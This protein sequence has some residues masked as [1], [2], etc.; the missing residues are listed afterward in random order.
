MLDIIS[1]SP[2][3]TH[4]WKNTEKEDVSQ[5]LNLRAE[6]LFY[7]MVDLADESDSEAPNIHTENE[8]HNI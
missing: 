5:E 7:Q 3:I 8:S 4:N 1:R 6:D 2:N